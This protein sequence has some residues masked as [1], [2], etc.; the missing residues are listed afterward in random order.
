MYVHLKAIGITL[1]LG[2]FC[3]SKE[4]SWILH[5]MLKRKSVCTPTYDNLIVDK[6]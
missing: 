6:I 5:E 2:M 4:S 3:E 1:S